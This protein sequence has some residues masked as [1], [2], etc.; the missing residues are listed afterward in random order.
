MKV[1]ELKNYLKQRGLK[2]TGR[3]V[4][5]VAR[6]FCAHENNVE[7]V[8]TAVEIEGDLRDA[9]E[10]K[11]KIDEVQLPYPVSMDIG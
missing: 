1:E 7:L 5:L 11:L 4:E 8:K 9:Y 3:K 10:R 2:I 6:V